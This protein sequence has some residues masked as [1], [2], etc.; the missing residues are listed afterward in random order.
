[1]SKL[2]EGDAVEFEHA[3]RDI[4]GTVIEV[5]PDGKLRLQDSNNYKYRYPPE[6]VRAKGFQKPVPTA[7]VPAPQLPANADTPA[8]N[9]D[10]STSNTNQ[11]N[12]DPMAKKKEVAAKVAQTKK[13]ATPKATEAPGTAIDTK[14]IKELTC[15]KHQRIF[16]L[17]ESGCD[18]AQIMKDA[19]CNAG[20]ISNVKKQYADPAN[21]DKVAT[22]K[23]LLA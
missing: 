17:M 3:G 4:E 19:G 11:L 13:A 6:K 2:K 16:L 8:T 14:K 23:A 21:A 9:A 5:L 22:A 12:S 20:E 18:K 10:S 7:E 1:M 15:K